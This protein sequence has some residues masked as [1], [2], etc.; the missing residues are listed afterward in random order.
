[1]LR[2]DEF[3]LNDLVSTTVSHIDEEDL[4]ALVTYKANAIHTR[5]PDVAA[6][7]GTTG[8]RLP[9]MRTGKIL[10]LLDSG[11]KVKECSGADKRGLSLPCKAKGK[12]KCK[13][14]AISCLCSPNILVVSARAALVGPAAGRP[15][16][17]R[18]LRLEQR[19]VD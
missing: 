14:A 2:A 8:C 12:K 16:V 7:G 17:P 3:P 4:L 11:V 19:V 9:G 15:S 10:L 5:L 18:T 6:H 13:K 1:M